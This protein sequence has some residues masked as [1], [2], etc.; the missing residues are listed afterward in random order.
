MLHA[1]YLPPKLWAEALNYASHIQNRSPHRYIKDQTL[2]EA[3]SDNK[4]KFAHFL[5]FGSQAWARI[6]YEKRKALDP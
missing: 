4:P 5:I 6:P 2:F 1:R 3:W